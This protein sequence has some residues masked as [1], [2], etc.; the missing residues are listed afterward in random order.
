MSAKLTRVCLQRRQADHK[1]RPTH[2]P[3]AIG[4]SRLPGKPDE[5]QRLV[6]PNVRRYSISSGDLG[7]Q[8]IAPLANEVRS[9]C[10]GIG[11]RRCASNMKLALG[12]RCIDQR[13]RPRLPCKP[14]SVTAA[15]T[16]K[17]LS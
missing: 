9:D 4:D 12:Q 14:P 1:D 11:A 8:P 5:Q 13:N 15:S 17:K 16:S 10:P 7:T 2:L 3:N 6:P